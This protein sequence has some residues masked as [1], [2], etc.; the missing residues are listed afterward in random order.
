[1]F[2][3]AAGGALGAVLKQSHAGASLANLVINTG[4][5][6]ILIPFVISGLLKI[7]QG[8]GTVAVVTAATLCAPIASKLGL[9]PILIFLASGAGAAAAVMSMT[10]SSGFTRTAWALI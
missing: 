8:S 10:V 9:N 3:T 7:V 2:I 6:F 5:P 4:L 1:M